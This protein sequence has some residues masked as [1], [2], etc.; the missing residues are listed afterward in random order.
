MKGKLE[1]LAQV[2][3]VKAK[4]D[5]G[6]RLKFWFSQEELLILQG[7]H[8]RG[9]VLGKVSLGRQIWCFSQCRVYRE[10]YTAI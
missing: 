1:K 8:K 3:S 7:S 6:L 10:H 5:L 2:E 9:L 4:K